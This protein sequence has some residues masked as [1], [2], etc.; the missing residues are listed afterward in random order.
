M[1]KV[2]SR[3]KEFEEFRSHP[4]TGIDLAIE[5]GHPLKSIADGKVSLIES[6]SEGIGKGVVITNEKGIQ[7]I[8]GH[9]DQFSVESGDQIARG[10]LIGYSGDSGFATGPH[11]HFGAKVN[12]QFIDPTPYLD[13][14]QQMDHLIKEAPASTP[15]SFWSGFQVEWGDFLANLYANIIYLVDLFNNSMLMQFFH[16]LF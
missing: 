15:F 1:W 4:H 12:G 10:E 2:T 6:G 5:K 7:F 13:D 3:Y 9:L 11:L 8:Y 14:I 16:Y